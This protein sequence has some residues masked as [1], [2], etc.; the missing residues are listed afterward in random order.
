MNRLF[1]MFPNVDDAAIIALAY[2]LPAVVARY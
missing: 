1:D 2:T